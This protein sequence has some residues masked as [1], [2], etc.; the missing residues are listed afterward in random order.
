MTDLP[1]L[2]GR[3]AE[4]G[5]TAPAASPSFWRTLRKPRWIALLALVLAVTYA[6]T[7]LGLWQL[8]VATEEGR[9]DARAAS[10]ARPVVPLEQVIRPHQEMTEDAAA[11][12]VSAQG[13]Y[14][15][16]RQVL[17]TDRRLG[18]RHGYWV[19]T[20]L[21]TADGAVLPVL[22]GFVE[23]A[24]DA[25]RPPATQV[26]VTGMFAPDEGPPDERRTLP[27]GQ[28]QKVE[29]GELVNRW[30]EDLYNGFLFATGETPALS[31]GAGS[32]VT[33]VPPPDAVR[34]ELNWRS[35]SYAAQWWVFAGFGAYMWWRMVREDQRQ[36]RLAAAGS[37]GGPLPEPPAPPAPE[38]P[39]AVTALTASP[40][41]PQ[42]ARNNGR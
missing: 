17:I 42:E 4:P 7:L 14:D 12:M 34:T 10:L 31:W 32:S 26:S 9:K 5:R 2:P 30:P 13:T 25:N 16:S 27:G 15:A 6:F 11:R 35:L 39:S 23:R 8:N 28:L 18:D 19:V 3:G 20:P 36:D 24:A 33:A 37:A 29:L 40:A 38:A 21:E 22:R 1:D 41:A